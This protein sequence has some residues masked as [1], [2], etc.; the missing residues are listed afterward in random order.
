MKFVILALFI[1]LSPLCFSQTNLFLV[2]IE[3]DIPKIEKETIAKDETKVYICGGDSGILTLVFPSGNGL[4]G[5]FVKLADKKILVVRNV[6]D[7]LVFSLK[8]EDGTLKQLIN[9][10]VS[11]LNKLDYRINIVSDKLKKAFMISAYDTVTEDN[12]SPVLNMFGDKITPQENEFIITTEIKETTSGYLE[13]GITK[14]E[15]T[16][17]YFLT[18]IKIGDKICNFVVDLAATN[19]LITMKN[20]PEGIKTEDLVAKQYSVEGVESIDAPSAGFGG[21]ISNLKTCTLPEIELGTVSFKQSLFYVI[22][23]LFKIKGKKIDGIIGIDLLQKFEGLE[24]AIDSTKKVDLLLG[25]NYTK[26][27]SGFISLPFTTANGHIFVKGKIGSSDI[28]FILDTGSP[29]SFIQSSMAAKENLI[30]VQSISVRGADG[31]KISTMNAMV[32]NITLEGNVISD[33]ETKIV[34]S[35]LFNSMGLKN[36]G[37]LLGNS[38]LK[39]YSKMCID[40]KDKKLRL[41]R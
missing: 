33:F 28:N 34:D 31:N 16:G 3:N 22:D 5:D 8:K 7:E 18:E 35:P 36:S 24:F 11:G 27:T 19:S 13:D 39:K 6:N 26:N 41:Y 15:F 30:G 4:S 17:N 23:T 29:F 21:N 25:K 14:I 20:L 32:N 10:P 2:T 37:G 9:A 38:F 40:F 12:N 1:A